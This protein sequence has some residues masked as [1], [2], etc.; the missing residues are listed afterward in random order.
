[1]AKFVHNLVE[2]APALANAAVTYSEASIGHILTLYQGWAGSSNPC[3][4]PY[5]YSELEKTRQ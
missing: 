3:W 2:K 4:N 1:M 5:S